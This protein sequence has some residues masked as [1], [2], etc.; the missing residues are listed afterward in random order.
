MPVVDYT[1]SRPAL[2]ARK[3]ARYVRLYG[4]ATTLSKVE[5]QY[6]M[7]GRVSP[8]RR[9]RDERAHV[10]IIG[11]GNFAYTTIAYHL[12]RHAGGVIRGAMDIVERRGGGVGGGVGGPHP[13]PE[14][15][16]GPCATARG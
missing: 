12:E 5:G 1:K 7:R 9:S 15:P 6:H 10:G 16:P 11:C 3:A 4:P 14:A 13:P 2:R 8:R